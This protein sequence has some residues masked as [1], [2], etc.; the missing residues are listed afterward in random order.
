VPLS[1]GPGRKFLLSFLPP[2]GAAMALTAALYAHG[3]VGLLPGLWLLSYGAAIV[4]A[5]TFSVRAVPLMGVGFM[6]V[7]VSRSP[8]RPPGPTPG[9][10]PASAACTSPS[11]SSSRGGT[12][13]S[14]EAA[15]REPEQE[16]EGGATVPPAKGRKRARRK[17]PVELD[18]VIHERVR[19]AIV[20]ALAGAESLSFNELKDLL[21]ITDGNLSVH[22]RRLEEA[23]F[24]A[25][26]K[27]FVDRVPRTEYSLTA[28]R[29]PGPR[30]VPRPH[31]IPDPA[32]ARGLS[33]PLPRPDIMTEEGFMIQSTFGEHG[34]FHVAIIMDGNGRWAQAR[35]L[36]RTAG[37]RAGATAVRRV[38][39][40][41]PSQG[42]GVLTLYAF[43]SDNWKRPGPGGPGAAAPAGELPAD[44]DGAVRGAGGAGRGAGAA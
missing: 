15:R 24:V 4:T 17:T 42:I 37:H 41:A 26:E 7:G 9:W 6:A 1:T 31:G 5:G 27:S 3:G 25:C 40:A 23:G 33:Q 2:V 19:L 22:A 10:P 12:V 39:E 8:H 21:D 18:R 44:G 20:S 43:S 35:G 38:V 11:D 14:G 30:R 28:G 36:P 29:S 32:G 13:A 34:G 16:R